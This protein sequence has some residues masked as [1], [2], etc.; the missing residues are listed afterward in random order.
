[1]MKLGLINSAFSQV[2]MDFE[3][4]IRHAKEIGFD[5][6]DIFTEAW[7]ISDAEKK[8]LAYHEAGRHHEKGTGRRPCHLEERRGKYQIIW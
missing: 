8:V 1:M 5:A 7:Q 6:I 2:G 3:D 4:G